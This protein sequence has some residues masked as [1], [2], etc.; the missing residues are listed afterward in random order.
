MAKGIIV[1]LTAEQQKQIRPIMKRIA[2]MSDQGK[3]GMAV[4]QV[5]ED[6]IGVGYL[7]HEQGKAVQEILSNLGSKT[8]VGKT[9]NSAFED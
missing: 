5:Y 7:T 3:P 6:H 2:K 1:L 4:A 8:P 9:R